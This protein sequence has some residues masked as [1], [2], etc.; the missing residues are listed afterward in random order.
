MLHFFKNKSFS[1]IS[2]LLGI[3]LTFLIC[4]FLYDNFNIKNIQKENLKG[5]FNKKVVKDYDDFFEVKKVILNGR[6]KA[7]KDLIKNIVNSSIYDNSNIFKYDALS[8]K[9]SLTELNW[10]NKVNIRKIFPNQIIVNIKE[11]KEF[12]IL[13][14]KEKYFLLSD[15]GKTI[16]AIKNP[17]AYNLIYLE[18]KTVKKNIEQVKNFFTEHP[19]LKRKTTKIVITP[20]N[21]WNIVANNIL[22]KLPSKDF[23]EAITKIERFSNL[24]HL[25]MVDLRFYKKKIFIKVNEKK[26]AMKNKK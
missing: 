15:E 13:K 7:D 1:K 20:N 17:Q 5:F 22:F 26:I 9:N 24:E 10:I 16:Y 19:E 6:Y 2:I 21:R 14:N 23:D 25:E 12:A 3:S 18:G 11:H 8:V 4:S